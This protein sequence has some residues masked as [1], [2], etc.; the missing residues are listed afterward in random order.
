MKKQ[1]ISFFILLSGIL[2]LTDCSRT[3]K[4]GF[5]MDESTAGRWPTDKDLFIKNIEAQGGEVVFRASEMDVAKQE[6]LATEMFAEGIDVLVMVPADMNEAAKIVMQA[7]R[8]GIRVVSYD[9]LT[10]NCGLDYYVSFDHVNVGEL[11]AKYLTAACPKGK[12]AVLGG[13]MTDNNSFLLRLGQ[14]NILQPLIDRGDIEIVYDNYASE[15]TDEE[16]Y[17]LMKECLKKNKKVDAVIAG[18]DRLAGGAIR[19]LQEAGVADDVCIAGMDADAD[20]CQ[21]IIAGTQSMTVYKPIE[22]IAVMAADVAMQIALEDRAPNMN[23][24]VN[25]G[26]KQVPAVL[27]P[28]MTV[29]K[30]TIDLTVV[31]DGYLKENSIQ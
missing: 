27:L 4:V 19:A 15:W 28:A 16:G 12:Y 13:A 22:A 3:V 2:L 8:E 11:Q 29:S 20:A 25:N 21:R 9:R 10:K 5:L 17:R 7:H 31:A 14:L 18:N 6:E 30:E 1:I 26:F 24:S 23:L